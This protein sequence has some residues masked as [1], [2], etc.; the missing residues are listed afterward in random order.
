[1]GVSFASTNTEIC[2][3]EGSVLRLNKIGTCIVTATQAGADD[4][5]AA[6]PVVRTFSVVNQTFKLVLPATAQLENQS[7]DLAGTTN[8]T[9]PVIYASQTPEVCAVVGSKAQ[10]KATGLCRV[11]AVL[12]GTA[13]DA[14]VEDVQSFM[15]LGEIGVSINDGSSY[16][17]S[18][19]VTIEL[20]W[21][22]GATAA[23]ISN[24]GGFKPSST[25]S[26]PL[27]SS[28]KWELD[29]SVK[30]SYTKIVYV[31]FTGPG[32]DS[33]ETYTDDIIL[34]TVSP[35]LDSVA[36]DY[37]DP[38]AKTV[39]VSSARI[40]NGKSFKMIIKASDRISGI[41]TV[42]IKNRTTGK[43]TKLKYVRPKSTSQSFQIK[44]STKIFLVRVLDRAGNTSSW[45]SLVVSR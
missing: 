25:R 33:T 17:R 41:G 7:V 16:T 18:K 29:D 42:E 4:W 34:D 28:I 22:R 1:L 19:A 20:V 38:K 2:T 40:A 14:A 45:K 8:S 24:D 44:S 3:V 36:V 13:G 26:V 15:V 10:L 21:P 27:A 30:G 9:N 32:I 12:Q 37:L 35:I 6:T 31:R 11:S 5:E 43:L 23:R 39:V